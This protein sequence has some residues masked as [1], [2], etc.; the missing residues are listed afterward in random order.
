MVTI[1]PGGPTGQLWGSPP[2]GPWPEAPGQD[3]SGDRSEWKDGSGPCWR[4]EALL[5]GVQGGLSCRCQARVQGAKYQGRGKGGQACSPL[6]CVP[7]EG[8]PSFLAHFW[9]LSTQGLRSSPRVWVPL[10][11]G[12]PSRTLTSSVPSL[13]GSTDELCPLWK[14]LVSWGISHPSKAAVYKDFLNFRRGS[15]KV[16][17]DREHLGTN[18]D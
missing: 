9:S 12:W 14:L 15:E 2:G 11:L 5:G 8:L 17:S 13:L 7:I 10:S 18:R 3:I 6:P 16:V 4:L 1:Q